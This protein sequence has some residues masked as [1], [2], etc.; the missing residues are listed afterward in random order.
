MR[1]YLFDRLFQWVPAWRYLEPAH[2]ALPGIQCGYSMSYES[3]CMLSI[4][5]R[6]L[7]Q[8]TLSVEKASPS[9]TGPLLCLKKVPPVPSMLGPSRHVEHMMCV[10]LGSSAKGSVRDV[11]AENECFTSGL[12]RHIG[13]NAL[14]RPCRQSDRMGTFANSDCESHSRAR[15]S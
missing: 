12:Q 9:G 14:A 1:S 5:R 6:Y 8:T 11:L 3:S 10:F 7:E 4:S 13:K 15:R 2:S